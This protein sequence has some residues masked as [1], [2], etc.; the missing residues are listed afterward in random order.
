MLTCRW[1]GGNFV[2]GISLSRLC[3]PGTQVLYR[4]PSLW[5]QGRKYFLAGIAVI[6]FQSVLIFAL[7]WQRA[8]R[9]KAEIALGESEEKFSKAFQ[10]SPLA[11]TIVRMTDDRYIEVNEIF[12]VNTGWLREEILGR[13]PLEIGLWSDAD[14]RT[15]FLRQLLE[16]GNVKDMEVSF[17]R[18]D[19]QV[20]T[21]LG[22]TE[23]I[24]L[25][26]EQ[27]ALSV[28]ADITERKQAEESMASVSS[29]LI[30][31]QEAERTRIAREL[32]D[33]INQRLAMVALILDS[34]RDALPASAIETNRQLEEA[35]SQICE[36]GNDIHALSH[37]LHSSRLEYLGLE[38]AASGFCREMS[39][40]QN[41]KINFHYGDIPEGLTDQ[42]SLCLFRVLQEALQNA[43]K[44]SGVDQFDV[45]FTDTR[46][47]SNLEYMIQALD[48]I[49]RTITRWTGLDQ[50]E[51]TA[52]IGER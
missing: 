27:C 29:R 43:V 40:R 48:S 17:R 34:T 39:E 35:S 5:E 8:R 47:K 6:A 18:K 7:F 45:S 51:G 28:I 11:I 14:Q 9:R 22:S 19:G 24:E 20:R 46:A 23:L 26:G 36:L 49:R 10:H 52:E 15:A 50:H 30:E 1:T 25:N 44:Y 38:V 12:E 21:C 37:R 16:N 2:D 13:T 42:I 4:E 31:A 3:L 41:V 33:D 32:H